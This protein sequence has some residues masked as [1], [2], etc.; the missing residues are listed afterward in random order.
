MTEIETKTL[1]RFVWHDLMSVDPEQSK[2]F[3]TELFGWR[4]VPTDMGPMGIYEMLHAGGTPIGGIVELKGEGTDGVPSHWIGYVNTDDI[5]TC[6]QRS[7]AGGGKT[8]VPTTE[9]PDTGKFALI[10]DPQG[11]LIS[12]YQN[13]MHDAPPLPEKPPVGHFC[14][15]ELH[16]SDPAAA[17]AFYGETFGWTFRDADIDGYHV[18]AAGGLDIGGMLQ[19]D[20]DSPA[21]PAWLTY[22]RV[23]DAD[24]CA[25]RA[26]E[27]GATTLA[28]PSEI[29]GVGRYAA[30]QSPEGATFAIFQIQGA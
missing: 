4:V 18:I 10:T 21:P 6:L 5:D 7:G 27:L 13:T 26:L 30:L 16:T 20:P 19:L 2:A 17:K 8:C 9:I 1:G 15:E 24:A 11:A 3:Y 12:P 23:E 28:P 25:A 29:P 14:W 22:V